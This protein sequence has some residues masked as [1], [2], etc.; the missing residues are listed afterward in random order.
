M[1]VSVPAGRGRR[2]E[3]QAADLAFPEPLLA[4]LQG[5]VH[6]ISAWHLHVFSQLSLLRQKCENLKRKGTIRIMAVIKTHLPPA[7]SALSQPSVGFLGTGAQTRWDAAGGHQ[8]SPQAAPWQGS[9]A[10]CCPGRGSQPLAGGRPAQLPAPCQQQEPSAARPH[11][12]DRS[13]KEL[14]HLCEGRAPRRW[15]PKC[16]PGLRGEKR[17]RAPVPSPPG[18]SPPRRGGDGC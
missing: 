9:P 6:P 15:T 18:P 1:Q 14:E 4:A 7:S 3:G 13:G 12:G 16:S 11:P 8:S 5:V 10:S 17:L 2:L